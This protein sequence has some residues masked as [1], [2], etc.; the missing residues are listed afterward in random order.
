[1][2]DVDSWVYQSPYYQFHWIPLFDEELYNF[3]RAHY[4]LKAHKLNEKEGIKY[5]MLTIIPVEQSFEETFSCYLTHRALL[6]LSKLG[7]GLEIAPVLDMP[8][9]LFWSDQ[10]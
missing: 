10:A 7:L 1:M 8:E 6:L 5:T 3:L 9:T 2:P 4:P